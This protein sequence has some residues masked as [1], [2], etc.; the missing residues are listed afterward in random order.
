M[1]VTSAT[2][3]EWIV[4]SG[5]KVRSLE[6]RSREMN[7]EALNEA[8]AECRNGLRHI[9]REAKRSNLDL[10]PYYSALADIEGRIETLRTT[11]SPYPPNE[12]IALFLDAPNLSMSCANWLERDIDYAKLLA[13]FSRDALILRAYYYVGVENEEELQSNRFLYWL[14]RN[15]YRLVTKQIKTFSDGE[16]KGNLDVEIAVDMLELVDKVDR[17]IL[18]SG[19]GDF[20]SLLER[21]G[22]K[23]VRTQVV[24]YWGRGEGPTA[25]DLINA[26][27]I[28]T[29]LAE[30]ID[31][32]A[33][34]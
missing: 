17:V 5:G 21:V 18:F 8:V 12:K 14:K 28:F 25:R 26:S 19:D 31:D 24:A 2:L 32:I 34:D 3:T 16:R 10:M 13:H 1:A 4:K 23:G 27:D 29:D 20:A 33:R 7:E 6:A 15:G 9:Y 30:I 22:Q 11:P